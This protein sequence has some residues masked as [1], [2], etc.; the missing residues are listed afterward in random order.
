MNEPTLFAITCV[1]IGVMLLSMAFALEGNQ[2][3]MGLIG[4]ILFGFGIR[5]LCYWCR[6]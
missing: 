3:A 4:G 1:I 2:I 5:Q 6:R